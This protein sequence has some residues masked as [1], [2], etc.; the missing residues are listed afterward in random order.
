MQSGDMIGSWEHWCPIGWNKEHML[1]VFELI[2]NIER[3]RMSTSHVHLPD[4]MGDF[5]HLFGYVD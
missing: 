1:F 5:C 2:Q 4:S 3:K